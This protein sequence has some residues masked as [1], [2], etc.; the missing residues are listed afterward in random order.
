MSCAWI[1]VGTL[2]CK[3][4]DS[5]FVFLGFC[6]N[7]LPLLFYSERQYVS[8]WVWLWCNKSFLMDTEIFFPSH[9]ILLLVLFSNIYKWKIHSQFAGCAKTGER[10]ARFGLQAVRFYLYKIQEQ[11]KFIC[12]VTLCWSSWLGGDWGRRVHLG[13]IGTIQFLD[14]CG[15]YPGVFT[16]WKFIVCMFFYVSIFHCS[17]RLKKNLNW[18]CGFWLRFSTSFAGRE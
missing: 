18:M 11:A 3:G 9:E 16:L 2:L 12:G 10:Q 8:K 1:G 13:E 4:P 14:L 5:I 17:E 7:Y 15:G 6:C